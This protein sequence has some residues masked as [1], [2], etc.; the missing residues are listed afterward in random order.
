LDR[1]PGFGGVFTGQ[2]TDLG[3]APV[4]ILLASM[5]LAQEQR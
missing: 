1:W 4:M 2:A 5:L 3:S